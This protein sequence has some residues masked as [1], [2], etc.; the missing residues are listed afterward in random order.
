MREIKTLKD[1][2]IYSIYM[3]IQH[4]LNL[5]EDEKLAYYIKQITFNGQISKIRMEQFHAKLQN[6]YKSHKTYLYM[7]TFTLDPTKNT[8]NEKLYKEVEQYITKLL[9]SDKNFTNIKIVK[10]G[11]DEDHKHIHWHSLIKSTEFL[12][13]NFFSHYMKKY[14]KVDKSSSKS[15]NREYII[16][17]ISKQHQPITLL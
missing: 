1:I 7:V 13:N 12:K 14:G 10:E 8:L 16:T 11:G 3:N 2:Y 6:Y 15:G 4:Y 5:N 17:Y 9:L